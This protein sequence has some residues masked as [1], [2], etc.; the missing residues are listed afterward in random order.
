MKIRRSDIFLDILDVNWFHEGAGGAPKGTLAIWCS[1][2]P[3]AA[4]DGSQKH[5]TEIIVQQNIQKVEYSMK[6]NEV[7]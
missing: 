3:P 2:L 1:G 4:D 6:F 5:R 7:Y